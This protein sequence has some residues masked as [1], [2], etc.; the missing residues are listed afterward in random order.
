MNYRVLNIKSLKLHYSYPPL[1]AMTMTQHSYLALACFLIKHFFD[2]MGLELLFQTH[3]YSNIKVLVLA[4]L[5]STLLIST[6]LKCILSWVVPHSYHHPVSSSILSRL[7]RH[8]QGQIIRHNP[9]SKLGSYW[10]L[11][12]PKRIKLYHMQTTEYY[13]VTRKV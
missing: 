5:I 2:E 9:G 3:E 10:L 1:S 12:L 6:L 8:A 11:L 7:I 4:V 13:E